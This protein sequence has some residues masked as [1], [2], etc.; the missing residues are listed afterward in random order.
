MYGGYMKSR[1]IV[2][3]LI[4]IAVV[5]QSIEA[6]RGCTSC[7]I[8]RPQPRAQ[9]TQVAGTPQ[10]SSRLSRQQAPVQAQTE[11][12]ARIVKRQA[13]ITQKP[14]KQVVEQ[15]VVEQVV[16]VEV[17]VAVEGPAIEQ[18]ATEES[19]TETVKTGMRARLAAAWHAMKSLVA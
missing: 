8:S 19:N 16:P 17:Q 15:P 2:S 6:K 11:R 14:V 9:Q 18:V 1:I 10:R 13:I 7:S 4:A 12:A 3:A 5:G